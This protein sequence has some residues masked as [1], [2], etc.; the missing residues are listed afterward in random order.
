MIHSVM[1]Q[2]PDGGL[3]RRRPF[4]DPHH[5]ASLPALIGG[6]MRARPGEI[7]LAHQ[8]VLF[9]DE[10]PE[11][12]RG[13]LEALRQPLETGHVTVS[14]VNAHMSYPARFQLVAAMNP[15]RCGY[16][17]DL[18]R[19]CSRVPQCGADYQS[20]ISGPILDRID[21]HTFVPEVSAHDLAAAPSGESSEKIR[22]R[23]LK[24]RNL[25]KDRLR[26]LLGE[27]TRIVTNAQV[28][29]QSLEKIAPLASESQAILQKAAEQMKLSARGYHRVL[30]VART[31]A[32]LEEEK[33]ISPTHISEALSFRP[34]TFS[35]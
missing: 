10:L 31:L 11:F 34:L 13:A 4:R 14:R 22:Q 21:L 35:K 8:G 25:Q 33:S 24:A 3:I 23:V 7:S 16:M 19:A 6:G 27:N 20:K 15:C 18:S 29:G 32:D 1:G 26:M 12:S 30:R 2:L 5:S 17:S 28:S 9:L